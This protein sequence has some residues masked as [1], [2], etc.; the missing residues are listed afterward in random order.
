MATIDTLHKLMGRYKV[1]LAAQGFGRSWRLRQK[2]KSPCYTTQLNEIL[3]INAF[4]RTIYLKTKMPSNF[5][6]GIF[7]AIKAPIILHQKYHD[8]C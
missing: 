7:Y 5:F 8:R 4:V 6:K 1:K 2:H 3:I